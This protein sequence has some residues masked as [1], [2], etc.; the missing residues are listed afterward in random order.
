MAGLVFVLVNP[1]KSSSPPPDHAAA[2]ATVATADAGPVVRDVVATTGEV[3][4]IVPAG[5]R[6]P[7]MRIELTP[8]SACWIEATA[9][10]DRIIY[11]LLHTGDRYAI[12]GYENL[13]LKVGDPSAL[14][15]SINGAR[16]RPLGSAG[17]STTVHL[18]RENS[19]RFTDVIWN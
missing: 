9:D 13:V 1:W 8:R 17:Q 11:K 16:G 12:E 19:R 15:Y 7:N 14:V 18:T 3:R 6:I 5:P 10:G 4:P 2:S